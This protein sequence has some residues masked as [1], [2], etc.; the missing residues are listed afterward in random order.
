MTQKKAAGSVAFHVYT[1]DYALV[2]DFVTCIQTG[3]KPSA[4]FQS[5]VKT[6]EVAEV[7]NAQTLLR[8]FNG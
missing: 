1:G 4:R 8:E 3:G 7:I 6:M 5:S 2:D